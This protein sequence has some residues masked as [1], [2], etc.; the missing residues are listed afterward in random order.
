MMETWLNREGRLGRDLWLEAFLRAAP[1]VLGA[2]FTAGVVHLGAVLTLPS[3]SPLSAYGRLAAQTEAFS[4]KVL[5]PVST[6]TPSLPF[7]DPFAALAVCR[8]DLSKGPLHVKVAGDGDRLLSVSAHSRAG[9]VFYASTDRDVPQRTLNILVMTQAQA[10]RAR[11]RRRRR[12]AKRRTASDGAGG[13][14][15]CPDTIAGVEPKRFFA[16]AKSAGR[17]RMRPGKNRLELKD[18]PPQVAGASKFQSGKMRSMT[19]VTRGGANAPTCGERVG[20][21]PASWERPL[22]A[23][24]S[25]RPEKT[26]LA[27][28]PP[29]QARRF[30][31]VA[32]P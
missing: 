18:L 28:L 31:A 5:P 6:E 22:P 25:A 8:Y 16:G 15:I 20:I 11:R 17:R 24:N 12:N 1:Y 13:G 26:G 19:R 32:F 10:S 4:L 23:G 27:R 30:C 3:F 7:A 2:I 14:R 21:L 9:V 29:A